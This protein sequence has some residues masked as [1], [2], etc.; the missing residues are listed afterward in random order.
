VTSATVSIVAWIQLWATVGLAF[1]EESS[2]G[3]QSLELYMIAQVSLCST[4]R[5]AHW[6]PQMREQF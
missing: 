3:L 4:R 6:T 5:Q 1:Q 2:N